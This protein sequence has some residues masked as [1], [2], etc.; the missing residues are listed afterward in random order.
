IERFCGEFKNPEELGYGFDGL[1]KR[2]LYRVRFRQVDLWPDYKGDTADT[3]D[4]DVYEHWLS[5]S[6]PTARTG[7][8]PT[9]ASSTTTPIRTATILATSMARTVIRRRSRTTPRRPVI[10]R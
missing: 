1:P 10:T 4:V 9:L 8:K 5:R 7:V 3:V 2:R 6:N